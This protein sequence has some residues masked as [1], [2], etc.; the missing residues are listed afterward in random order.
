VRI[1]RC[2]CFGVPFARL[3]EEAEA[4]GARTVAELQERVT[5]GQKCRMCHPYTR[6]MLRTGEVVFDRII[7]DREQAAR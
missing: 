1:D 3:R 4:S 6:E 2:V 7:R 5:F